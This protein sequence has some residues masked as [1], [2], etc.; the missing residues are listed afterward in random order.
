GIPL[1]RSAFIWSMIPLALGSTTETMT[2]LTSRWA[3]TCSRR[4]IWPAGE[5]SLRINSTSAP[6]SFAASSKPLRAASQ[7]GELLLVMKTKRGRSEGDEF[8]VSGCLA[9]EQ[10]SVNTAARA[11]NA[12][13]Q[14]L[15]EGSF[16]APWLFLNEEV[17]W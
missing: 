6:N 2:P 9:P 8:C 7:N 3:A 12:C 10:Q 17:E 15:M 16:Q 4:R 5:L 1:A 11:G 14:N 13:L